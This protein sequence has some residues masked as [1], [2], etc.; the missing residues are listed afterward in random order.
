MTA[1]MPYTIEAYPTGSRTVYDAEGRPA[2]TEPTGVLYM[3]MYMPSQLGVEATP[4]ELA[5]WQYIKELERQ[6]EE[7]LTAPGTYAAT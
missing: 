1:T 6:I 3:K 5:V 7:V 4:E 2:S